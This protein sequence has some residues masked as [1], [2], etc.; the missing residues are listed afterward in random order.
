MFDKDAID[1]INEGTGIYQAT[2]AIASAFDKNKA[3]IALPEK[4]DIKDLEPFLPNRRRARSTMS[5][6]VTLSFAGY[7]K[8]HIEDG[9]MVFVNQDDMSACAVLNLGTPAK[10][11]HADNCAVLRL[12]ATAAYTALTANASG[13]PSSQTS[14]AEFLE[15]WADLIACYNEDG[16]I[17]LPVAVA[18]IRKLSI[19][20]MRKLETSEQS[21]SASR[22]TFEAVKAT[23]ADP[24]PTTIAFACEPYNGLPVRLF[25]IRLAIVTAADKPQITLRIIKQEEHNEQMAME[26]ADRVRD[27]LGNL[28]PVLIG[29]YSTV[30]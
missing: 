8:Q 3:A 19:E 22:S 1:A 13:R 5:T 4:F 10:P 23:S 7:A 12:K 29:K 18:A 20:S 6:N 2:N 16:E 11:G 17:K 26:F 27:S 28:M 30:K 14:V 24:I 15:D 21:L 9:A 25:K